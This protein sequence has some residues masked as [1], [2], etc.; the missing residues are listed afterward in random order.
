MCCLHCPL[1]FSD[2][3]G[4]RHYSRLH[5]NPRRPLLALTKVEKPSPSAWAHAASKVLDP[6]PGAIDET[7]PTLATLDP[8]AATSTNEVLTILSS[9]LVAAEASCVLQNLQRNDERP[10]RSCS[11]KRGE[12]SIPAKVH[13]GGEQ[14]QLWQRWRQVNPPPLGNFRRQERQ[15]LMAIAASAPESSSSSGGVWWGCP[16][17]DARSSATR[18]QHCHIMVLP[19]ALP[20]HVIVCMA[21]VLA[22]VASPHSAS[23]WRRYKISCCRP[24]GSSTSEASSVKN[25]LRRL[26]PTAD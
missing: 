4:P 16:N 15:T 13:A 8:L 1:L 17:Y 3:G 12:D 6:A 14:G 22:M 2:H 10:R 24:R 19:R 21:L 7:G 9:P 25:I 20:G 26:L 23:S 5:G 18:A 11:E